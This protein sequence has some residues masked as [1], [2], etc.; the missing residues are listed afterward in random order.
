MWSQMGDESPGPS[1]TYYYDKSG[2]VC[3][4]WNMFDQVMLRPT[5]LDR[6]PQE[7]VKVLTGC[8]SVNFLDSKGRPNTKI[9]SDHLPVLLKLHV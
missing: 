9:A 6:F 7:G 4:F 8:G 2:D 1:G 5:L 3:Y